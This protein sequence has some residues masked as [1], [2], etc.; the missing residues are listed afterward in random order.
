MAFNANPTNRFSDARTSRGSA[1][2]RSPGARC[3]ASPRSG[4][5]VGLLPS[6]RPSLILQTSATCRLSRSTKSL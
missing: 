5:T 2:V 1:P 4:V 3:S 6:Q